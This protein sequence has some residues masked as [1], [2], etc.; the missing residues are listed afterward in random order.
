MNST[1]P[2]IAENPQQHRS[3]FAGDHPEKRKTAKKVAV[4]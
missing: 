1:D 4:L 3:V 2:V